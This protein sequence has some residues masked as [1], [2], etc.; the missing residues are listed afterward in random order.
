MCK[1]ERKCRRAQKNICLFWPSSEISA[2]K[3]AK[4]NCIWRQ[5]LKYVKYRMFV[6]PIY[7]SITDDVNYIAVNCSSSLLKRR[8]IDFISTFFRH[9][10]SEHIFNFSFEYF[11]LNCCHDM[12]FNSLSF[13][14]N[15][16]HRLQ[17]ISSTKKIISRML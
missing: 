8:T 10:N 3:N 9:I 11:N 4:I 7:V 13:N 1:R 16:A 14:D 17:F 15:C 6:L 2:N 5:K 12:K